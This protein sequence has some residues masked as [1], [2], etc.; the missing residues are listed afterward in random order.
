MADT[1]YD[2]GWKA[3][4]VIDPR[5]CP[6]KDAPRREAWFQGYEDAKRQFEND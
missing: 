1:I 2:E 4:G 6:Y 3:Y 5:K